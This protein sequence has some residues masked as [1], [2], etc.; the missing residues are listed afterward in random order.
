MFATGAA[1][2]TRQF[3]VCLA[4]KSAFQP[5]GETE[6]DSRLGLG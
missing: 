1:G 4:F 2:L 5:A 3:A 6:L